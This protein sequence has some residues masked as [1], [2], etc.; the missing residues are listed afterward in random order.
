MRGCLQ[1]RKL[2]L[3][4]EEVLGAWERGEKALFEALDGYQAEGF[5]IVLNSPAT[6]SNVGWGGNGDLSRH[7]GAVMPHC[8]EIC[9]REPHLCDQ[10]LFLDDKAVTLNEFLNLSY[11]EIIRLLAVT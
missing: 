6:L 3:D 2:V 5:K 1:V 9:F 4:L 10:A 8:D 7:L 11:E